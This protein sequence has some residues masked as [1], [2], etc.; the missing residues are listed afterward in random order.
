MIFQLKLETKISEDST[1]G[2]LL[3]RECNHVNLTLAG[4]ETNQVYQALICKKFNIG[5]EGARNDNLTLLLSKT[6]S[7][8]LQLKKGSKVNLEVQFV[9]ERLEMCKM[10][11]ILDE[12][13]RNQGEYL[14]APERF[15]SLAEYSGKYHIR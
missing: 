9:L 1:E 12:L 6:C 10:H 13:K 2:M 4:S 11:Y 3:L 7:D 8:H 15:P 14:V 5:F